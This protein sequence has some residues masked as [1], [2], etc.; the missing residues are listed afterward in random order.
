[1][2][3]LTRDELREKLAQQMPNYHI[4]EDAETRAD[5][6]AADAGPRPDAV[7]PSLRATRHKY[8]REIR[9]GAGGSGAVDVASQ[10][11]IAPE[12]TS[13]AELDAAIRA[14]DDGAIVRMEPNEPERR[15]GAGAKA[16]IVD[17]DG[18]ITGVQG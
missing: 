11:P 10:L 13:D 5:L 15:R 3:K 2:I 4:A 7:A 8:R 1:M 12:S 14:T 6:D 9:H 16:V 17:K 18:N